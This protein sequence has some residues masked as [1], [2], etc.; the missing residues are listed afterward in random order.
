MQAPARP[1]QSFGG[2]LQEDLGAVLHHAMAGD[3]GGF[4]L[5][6]RPALAPALAGAGVG[7]AGGDGGCGL[8][9]R[10]AQQFGRRGGQHFHLQVDAVQQRAG[11]PPL[12]ARHGLGRAAAGAPAGQRRTQPTAGARVHGGHQLK[13]GRKSGL[14]RRARDGDAAGFHRLTQG[15]ECRARELGHLVEEQHAAV[16]QRD[17]TRPGRRPAARQRHRA[18]RVVRRAHRPLAERQRVAGMRLQALQ[19]RGGQGFV[20]AHG[21]QQPGQALGQHRLARAR[22]AHQQQA[23][24]AGRGDLQRTFGGGLASHVLQVRAWRHQRQRPGQGHGQR[25]GGVAGLQGGHHFEQRARPAHL[26]PRH[27]CGLAGAALG[28]HQGAAAA[29]AV[30][31][32]GQR[33]RAA[34]GPQ[35]A[36]QRQFARELAGSQ[37]RGVDGVHGRQDAQRDG[38]VEAPRLLGQIGRSQ[39]DGDALV[40]RESETA[41]LQ[42]GANAL[43]RFLDFDVG[44]AHQHEAGQAVGQLHLDVHL[45]RHQAVEGSA[46]HHG[47]GHWVHLIGLIW[48][49]FSAAPGAPSAPPWCAPVWGPRS[50]DGGP[51]TLPPCA[52]ARVWSVRGRWHG[53]CIPRAETLKST[54]DGALT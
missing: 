13:A 20:F 9:Q 41:L 54:L 36:G 38:Q 17:F 47:Q 28:Q 49:P 39:V 40:H 45:G 16:G 33:Q 27:A 30:R 34:H 10:G 1:H 22:R 43:A 52:G 35:F 29:L 19:G 37:P 18:G 24:A 53:S 21:R 44:Q 32:Q 11:Q 50:G 48:S 2:A 8:A 51:A 23:V 4:H 31:R 25:H 14:A 3:V 15:F 26:Q 5:A 6:V 12:V 7:H 46:H 42:R